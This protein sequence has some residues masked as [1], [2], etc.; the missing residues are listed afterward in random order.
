MKHTQFAECDVMQEGTGSKTIQKRHN[1]DQ[2][3]ITYIAKKKY[4]HC[5]F[6]NLVL[7]DTNRREI[8]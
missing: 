6:S 7:E 5:P 4:S 3:Q 1:D 8:Y 2:H